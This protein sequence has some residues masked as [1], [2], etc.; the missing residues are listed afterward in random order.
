MQS[1][2]DGRQEILI[3]RD[4]GAIQFKLDHGLR[5]AEGSKLG[6]CLGSLGRTTEHGGAPRKID[7]SRNLGTIGLSHAGVTIALSIVAAVP[8]AP[9]LA[10]RIGARTTL[11][12]EDEMRGSFARRNWTFCPKRLSHASNTRLIN[13]ARRSSRPRPD[14]R[15][16]HGAHTCT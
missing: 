1:I 14:G 3:G 16:R 7:S 11:R 4:D 5:L 12:A 8:D 13:Q 10:R 2:A 9:A 15:F 6:L